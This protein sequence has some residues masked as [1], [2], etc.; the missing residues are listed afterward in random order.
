ATGHWSLSPTNLEDPPSPR[1][2]NHHSSTGG[3]EGSELDRHAR[4]VSRLISRSSLFV[5]MLP[6][7]PAHG[8]QNR[9]WNHDRPDTDERCRLIALLY[10][11]LPRVRSLRVSVGSRAAGES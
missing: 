6:E 7:E 10:R 11:I 9:E 8:T 2:S 5:T 3:I 1:R 4:S